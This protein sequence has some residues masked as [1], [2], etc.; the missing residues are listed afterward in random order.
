[1][2]KRVEE[3]KNRRTIRL[4]SRMGKIRL[5]DEG[6]WITTENGH[7]IHLNGEGEPDKGNKHV[8]AAMEG[9]KSSSKKSAP[10][11]SDD[12][13]T[14]SPSRYHKG[15]M[16][17]KKFKEIVKNVPDDEAI[18]D[19]MDLAFDNPEKYYNIKEVM[20]RRGLD[21]QFE[22][23]MGSANTNGIEDVIKPAIEKKKNELKAM[24]PS[25]KKNESSSCVI[26]DKKITF[27]NARN[28]GTNKKRQPRFIDIVITDKDT[29]ERN[30][31]YAALDYESAMKHVYRIAGL[32]TGDYD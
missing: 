14:K 28:A 13:S 20:R 15:D 6:R 9:K 7:H 30:G 19:A 8:I 5:D 3:Y 12:F 23:E 26:G 16:T 11:S 29:G 32:R 18:Q 1:M 24:I 2:S 31:S 27:Y 25:P 21:E 4:L 17:F 22:W 10:K